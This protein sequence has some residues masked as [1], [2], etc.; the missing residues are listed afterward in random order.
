MYLSKFAESPTILMEP[1]LNH[2]NLMQ[3]SHPQDALQLEHI[4]P[5]MILSPITTTGIVGL[6][7]TWS[8]LDPLL[9]HKNETNS[10]SPSLSLKSNVKPHVLLEKLFEPRVLRVR[11]ED[12]SALCQVI[13][14][15][16]EQ[17]SE[18]H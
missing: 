18:Y 9:Y 3:E 4:T 14:E 17:F 11:K 1:S 16:Q 5:Q 7:R 10:V 12:I 2:L 15:F 13:S 6:H 8:P